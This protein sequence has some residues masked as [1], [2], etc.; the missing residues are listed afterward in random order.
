ME[1]YIYFE[2]F[3]YYLLTDSHIFYILAPSDHGKTEVV[4]QAYRKS[5]NNLGLDYVDLYL[6]HFPG[7]A[8]LN[9]TDERNKKLR[10]DTWSAL[11][12]LYDNGQ[13]NAVG[14]SN[15]TVNHLQELIRNHSVIPAVNQVKLRR[16]I[17]K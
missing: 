5:L 12:E 11:E 16:N 1:S 14:V 10:S 3:T 4:E 15:F 2:T 17:Q 8:R 6:I 7:A 13:V 9:A